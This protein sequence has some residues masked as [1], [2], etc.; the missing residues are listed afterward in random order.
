[1]EKLKKIMRGGGE[2]NSINEENREELKK[3]LGDVVWYISALSN[4]LGFSF[5]D[6]IAKNIEKLKSRK[7]R[8]VIHGSGDN[9]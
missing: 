5:D 7:D 6:V 9:R 8:G 4:D 1:M 3:E 2:L